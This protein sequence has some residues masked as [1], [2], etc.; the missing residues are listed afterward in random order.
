MRVGGPSATQRGRDVASLT[1][2]SAV[3]GHDGS[4]LVVAR[5]AASAHGATVTTW[6][7]RTG[8]APTQATAGKRPVYDARGGGGLTFDGVDDALVL[9]DSLSAGN[10]CTAVVVYTPTASATAA[11]LEFGATYY[12]TNGIGLFRDATGATITGTGSG[13]GGNYVQSTRLSPTGATCALALIADRGTSPDSAQAVDHFGHIADAQVGVINTATNYAAN[14]G[15]IGARNDG[16]SLPL[17][18]RIHAAMVLRQALTVGQ[19]CAL[20]AAALRVTA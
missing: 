11:M 3:I 15:W 12:N 6:T 5:D 14:A 18:G 1:L 2:A 9:A 4:L 8:T 10:A 13:T 20:V 19:T 7:A 16:A 17:A